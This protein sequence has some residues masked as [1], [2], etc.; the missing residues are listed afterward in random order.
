MTTKQEN[1]KEMSIYEKLCNIQN[2]MKVP[3]DLVNKFGGYK[4]RNA[5]SIFEA[6]K[7][8]CL[9]YR[10]TLTVQ[11]NIECIGDRYYV[12][13]VCTLSD[14][15]SNRIIQVTAYARESLTKKGMDD[16]QITG[17][18]SSYARKYALNGMFNLD[19]TKDEDTDEYYKQTGK[20]DGYLKKEITK[21]QNELLTSYGFDVKEVNK[22]KGIDNNKFILEK[23]EVSSQDIGKLT[24]VQ[25]MET[26]IEYYKKLIDAKKK[27]LSSK[28]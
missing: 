25:E 5:E 23:T 11:D 27:G 19:D 14:W 15:D 26:L 3:K 9:E 16:S 24:D 1:I 17:T 21:L 4:Y 8:N 20:A 2:K 22:E 28:K 13:A 6:A 18:A 12:N 10:V 7:P